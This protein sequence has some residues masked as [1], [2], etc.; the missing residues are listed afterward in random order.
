MVEV[1]SILLQTVRLFLHQNTHVKEKSF[2]VNKHHFCKVQTSI[3]VV[4]GWSNWINPVRD[5]QCL[6]YVNHSVCT[7]SILLHKVNT[8]INNKLYSVTS[9]NCLLCLL[10]LFRGNKQFICT[11]WVFN[12]KEYL[13]Q[14]L[15]CDDS[16]YK[17]DK[18][19]RREAL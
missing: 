4:L 16:E 19:A 9:F 2:A 12:T 3:E 6:F 7:F 17:M 14:I 13:N 10:T 5:E 8:N 1:E 18:M 15:L 11:L